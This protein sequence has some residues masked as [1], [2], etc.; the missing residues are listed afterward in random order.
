MA[1]LELNLVN[2]IP[3]G[4]WEVL[5]E[6]N[7]V[8]DNNLDSESEFGKFIKLLNQFDVP[9]LSKYSEQMMGMKYPKYKNKISVF[10]ETKNYE[11]VQKLLVENNLLLNKTEDEIE[12]LKEV[13]EDE[14]VM[15]KEYLL[16]DKD[17]P[18]IN[19]IINYFVMIITFV[20]VIGVDIFLIYFFQQMYIG[21]VGLIIISLILIS[22]TI[23]CFKV[24]FFGKESK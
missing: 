17:L 1:K 9:F 13:I 7:M 12:E 2:E 19:K 18:S 22:L 11:Y 21:K 4:E 5:A 10:I 20:M 8:N 15:K 3:D 6:C 14:S 23:Y 24:M 16:T